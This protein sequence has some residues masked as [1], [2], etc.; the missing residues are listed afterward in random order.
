[1]PFRAFQKLLQCGTIFTS[2][3]KPLDVSSLKLKEMRSKLN[4]WTKHTNPFLRDDSNQSP[5]E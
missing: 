1:M 4:L 2:D 5:V 3:D